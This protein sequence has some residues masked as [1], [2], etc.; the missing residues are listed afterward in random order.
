MTTLTISPAAQAELSGIREQA[1]LKSA[2][3]DTLG[4]FLSTV[5]YRKLLYTHANSLVTDEELENARKQQ[6]GKST[7]E[8]L[9]KLSQVQL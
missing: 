2:S 8:L 5:A 4:M 1:E 3:G 7:Q 9:A 6:G